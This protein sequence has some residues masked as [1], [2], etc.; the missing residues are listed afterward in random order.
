VSIITLMEV[1][2]FGIALIVFLIGVL[3]M[4]RSR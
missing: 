4:L 2:L 1:T 3:M